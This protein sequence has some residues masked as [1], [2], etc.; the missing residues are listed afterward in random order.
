[1]KDKRAFAEE[2]A[3]ILD[4]VGAEV[5]EIDKINEKKTGIILRDY[6][7][8]GAIFYIPD[9]YAG[10]PCD[11]ARSIFYEWDK[12]NINF[13]PVIAEVQKPESIKK[14][15]PGLVRTDW[16][17]DFL[18]EIVHRNISDLSVY[19]FL[20]VD[21]PDG[22]TASVKITNMVALLNGWTEEELFR[23]AKENVKA[24]TT[25]QPLTEIL[26]MFGMP[27]MPLDSPLNVLTTQHFSHGAGAI[28]GTADDLNDKFMLV[29]SSIH[30]W[31]VINK[32]MVPYDEVAGIIQ[33]VNADVV[34]PGERLSDH[35]YTVSDFQGIA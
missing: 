33:L 5:I 35:P 15:L 13:K 9:D 28:I 23:H 31:I 34:S 4:D 18:K 12:Q 19:Y 27:V 1:M 26:G 17:E 3:R 2:V 25:M 10:T 20:P 24:Q 7:K 21:L 29:P 14:I 6:E 11:F 22:R 16:N 8:T 32:D 30:E